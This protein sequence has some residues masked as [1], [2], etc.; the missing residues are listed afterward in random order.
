MS[1]PGRSE[2]KKLKS[3]GTLKGRQKYGLFLAE[4]IRVLEE[5]YRFHF[6]PQ[7]VYFD[8]DGL[9]GR[10]EALVETFR[11]SG[12]TVSPVTGH[13]IEQLAE[14]VT[15]QGIIAVF[16][17]PDLTLE[18]HLSKKDGLVLYLD[19]IADPGN[20]GTLIRSALAFGVNLVVL[21]PATV[22]PFNG[23]VIRSSAGTIFGQKLAIG[24]IDDLLEKSGRD[25]ILIGAQKDGLAVRQIL[26]K[27]KSGQ[28]LIVAVGSEA[29]GLSEECL[30]RV[31]DL[32]GIEHDERV[33]SLNAAVAG[34]IILRDMYNYLHGVS[35]D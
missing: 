18:K 26:S 22:D 7:T 35:N 24:G 6:R 12:C 13:E 3:L 33:E 17:I 32:V 27:V 16:E 8:R 31:N 4:G 21:S 28:K 34:S 9:D 29:R 2:I 23:K 11:R 15:P 25:S 20:V 10:G 14:S 19:N 1:S 30:K 5:S